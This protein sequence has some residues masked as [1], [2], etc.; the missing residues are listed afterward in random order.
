MRLDRIWI[1]TK[2]TPESEIVDIL[3]SSTMDELELQFRGGLEAKNIVAIYT[4][5]PEA[6]RIAEG[7]LL[8]RELRISQTAVEAGNRCTYDPETERY[9]QCDGHHRCECPPVAPVDN[10]PGERH[11]SSESHATLI[12]E[13]TRLRTEN[14]VLRGVLSEAMRVIRKVSP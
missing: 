6:R 5:E 10:Q 7:Q 3:F 11:S 4:E 1:V 14:Q 12:S 2:P 8:V 9:S 13:I